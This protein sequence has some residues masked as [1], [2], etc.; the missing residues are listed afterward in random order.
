[1]RNKRGKENFCNLYMKKYRETKNY[2]K[3]VFCHCTAKKCI[4]GVVSRSWV[5]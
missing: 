1:M 4:L 2:G 5:V 3:K